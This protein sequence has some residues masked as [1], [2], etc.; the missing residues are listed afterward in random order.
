MSAL[1]HFFCGWLA[2]MLFAL[3]VLVV[4]R[5]ESPSRPTWQA[6][7]LALWPLQLVAIPAGVLFVFF[8]MEDD[9]KADL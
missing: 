1:R 4:Y 3:F 9:G 5:G 6:I 7:R 8:V 2:M